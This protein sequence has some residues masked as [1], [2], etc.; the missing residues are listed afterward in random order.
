MGR[1][2]RWPGALLGAGAVAVMVVLVLVL[3]LVLSSPGAPPRVGT[4][5]SG[6]GVPAADPAVTPKGWAPVA[7]GA[8]LSRR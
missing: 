7:Y 5:T 8:A 3:M 4:L 6:L 2:I 1:L